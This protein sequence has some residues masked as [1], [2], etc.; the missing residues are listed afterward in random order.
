MNHLKL[1]LSLLCLV[2]PILV[3]AQTTRL[4]TRSESSAD[5]VMSR[6]D[7]T[8]S[9]YFVVKSDDPSVD[10]LPLLSTKAD[11]SIAGVIADVKV[12]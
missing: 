3:S 10:R 5:S 2:V 6:T 12:K 7:R 1:S 4:G 11:V 8:L 9:P